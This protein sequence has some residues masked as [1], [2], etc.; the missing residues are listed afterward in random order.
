MHLNSLSRLFLCLIY[1]D[2][3]FSFG[4]LLEKL[5]EYGQDEKTSGIGKQE[6]EAIEMMAM[7]TICS[8]A[9]TVLA[10]GGYPAIIV[11]DRFESNG[12]PFGI[13]FRN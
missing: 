6:I 11:A 9:S 4:S 5:K 13:S 7:L 2:N 12:M 1:A 10:I 8:N 3:L